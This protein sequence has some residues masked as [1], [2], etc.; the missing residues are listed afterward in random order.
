MKIKAPPGVQVTKAGQGNWWNPGRGG[1]AQPQLRLS[2]K[3]YIIW[4]DNKRVDSALS[5]KAVRAIVAEMR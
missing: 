5:M 4:R 3:H 1:N 2:P